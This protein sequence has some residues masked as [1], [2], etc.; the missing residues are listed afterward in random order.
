MI[1][2]GIAMPRTLNGS[3]LWVVK[4]NMYRNTEPSYQNLFT[5]VNKA[6]TG[7][8][9]YPESPGIQFLVST[10]VSPFYLI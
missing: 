5:G 1:L 8:C 4:G 2:L 10:V 6:G 9:G 7:H 3:L